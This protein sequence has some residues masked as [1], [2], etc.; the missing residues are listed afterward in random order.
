MMVRPFGIFCLVACCRVRRDCCLAAL[1]CRSRAISPRFSPVSLLRVL[2]NVRAAS[3]PDLSEVK[4]DHA[5]AGLMKVAIREMH[6][7]LLMYDSYQ[8]LVDYGT[9]QT[10]PCWLTPVV[11][12]R[13][14]ALAAAALSTDLP[15]LLCHLA[16]VR[17]RV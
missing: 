16:A 15:F 13:A 12:L 10:S 7:P 3:Y 17:V 2:F 5:L 14:A 8:K 6:E 4:D 1:A 11:R 9:C